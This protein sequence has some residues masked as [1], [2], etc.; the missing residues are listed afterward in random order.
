VEAEHSSDEEEEECEEDV[1]D[2]YENDFVDP[3]QAAGENFRS[4]SIPSLETNTRT[5]Q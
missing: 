3:T 5:S 1:D 4:I 2:A